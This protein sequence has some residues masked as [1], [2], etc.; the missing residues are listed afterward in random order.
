MLVFRRTWFR[1]P[2]GLLGVA[3][4]GPAVA[5]DG[6]A[7][8]FRNLRNRQERPGPACLAPAVEDRSLFHRGLFRQAHGP[9]VAGAVVAGGRNS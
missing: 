3:A 4:R 9:A 5:D 7:V 8:V 2:M 6:A 1:K